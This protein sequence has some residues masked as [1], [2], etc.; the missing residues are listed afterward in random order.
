MGQNK[1]IEDE[2]KTNELK[3]L[4]ETKIIQEKYE[5]IIDST[6]VLKHQC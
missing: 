4:N 3:K 5:R 2:D 6:S 1:L